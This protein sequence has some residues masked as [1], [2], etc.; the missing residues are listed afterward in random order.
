MTKNRPATA[1]AALL[2]AACTAGI[3]SGCSTANDLLERKVTTHHDNVAEMAEGAAVSADWVPEDAT[4]ITVRTPV[5]TDSGAAVL[6][7]TS[8]SDLAAP[9][10]ET[11]RNSSPTLTLENAPDAY[12]A[13][14]VF[15][16]GEWSVIRSGGQWFGWT[17]NT[18]DAR[19]Q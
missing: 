1:V 12:K 18:G 9:C 13:D 5:E 3:L 4:E 11:E 17:P 14:T 2:L 6:L 8:A 15:V 19:P 16:C 10:E 7:L